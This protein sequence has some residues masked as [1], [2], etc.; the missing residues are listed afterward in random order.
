VKT[1]LAMSP[2]SGACTTVTTD[3]SQPPAAKGFATPA[4]SILHTMPKPR[5]G[6]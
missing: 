1:S 5:S 6:M 4:A 3:D 2:P